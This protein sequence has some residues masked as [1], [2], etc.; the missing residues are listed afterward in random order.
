MVIFSFALSWTHTFIRHLFVIDPYSMARFDSILQNCP[1][2]V[3]SAAL[4]LTQTADVLL[5]EH[6]HTHAHAHTHTS[7]L[8]WQMS[9]QGGVENSN[10]HTVHN[11]HF[12]SHT[13]NDQCPTEN[14]SECLHHIKPELSNK[15]HSGKIKSQYIHCFITPD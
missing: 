14:P 8:A 5:K 10:T 15:I 6:V 2:A 4:Q 12:T 11:T 1:M 9:K 13:F 3:S 7:S